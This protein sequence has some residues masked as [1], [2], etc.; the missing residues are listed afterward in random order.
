[1]LMADT[2]A[3]FFVILGLL[4]AFPALWLMARGLWPGT[5]TAAR[6]LFERGLLRS[7]ALGLP[8]VM[9]V[10]LTT[11][12]VSRAGTPGKIAAVGLVCFA[13]MIA[14]C[15]VAGLATLI[16]E[17]L[18]TADD[19]GREWSATLRGGVILALTWLLPVLG[20]FV[21]LPLTMTAGLGAALRA[22][23]SSFG[24]RRRIVDPVTYGMPSDQGAGR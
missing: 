16:G 7:L 22:I 20:W 12:L 5:V 13:I 21:I 6:D 24:R 1:M 8:V 4:L 2:M 17:R 11:A 10:I 9:A 14:A 15:G 23:G 19:V 18:S 3:V